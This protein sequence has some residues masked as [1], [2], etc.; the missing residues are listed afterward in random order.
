MFL[1]DLT[2]REGTFRILDSGNVI[3]Y[4]SFLLG[5]RNYG[6]HAANHVQRVRSGSCGLM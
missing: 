4:S 6:E 2:V 3:R 1:I 5:D